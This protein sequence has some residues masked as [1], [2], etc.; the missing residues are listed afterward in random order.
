MSRWKLHFATPFIP[1]VISPGWFFLKIS[2]QKA[3]ETFPLLPRNKNN[4]VTVKPSIKLKT[5][6]TLV[7]ILEIFVAHVSE[8][9][10]EVANTWME[11]KLH[12]LQYIL[13]ETK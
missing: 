13:M 5:L 11:T 6:L 12:T 2:L 9:T 10:L 1:V 7:C 4:L 3:I 8:Y